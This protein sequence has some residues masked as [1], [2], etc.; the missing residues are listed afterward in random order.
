MKVFKWSLHIREGKQGR[1]KNKDRWN[2]QK[3]ANEIDFNIDISVI[4]L[5]VNS[6]TTPIKRQ[7]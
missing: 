2:K 4:A 3:M 7:I 6:L 5:N 1:I